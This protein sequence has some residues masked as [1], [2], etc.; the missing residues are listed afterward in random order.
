MR[1]QII[2]SI[3]AAAL[4]SYSSIA[5]AEGYKGLCVDNVEA[6]C[7]ER[8]LRFH[9]DGYTLSLCEENCTLVNPVNVRDLDAILYDFECKGDYGDIPN[10]RVMVLTQTDYD[11]RVETLFIDKFETRKIVRC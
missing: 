3:L 5:N 7:N 11:G 2:G 8:L 10:Q 6:G 4:F 9:A 1:T